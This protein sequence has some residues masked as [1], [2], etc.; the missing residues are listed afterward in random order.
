MIGS[1]ELG[2]DQKSPENLAPWR[3]SINRKCR[4][5]VL[6]GIGVRRNRVA[7]SMAGQST[8]TFGVFQGRSVAESLDRDRCGVL[9]RI[10]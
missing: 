2:R 6:R 4:D 7:W 8:H 10:Q 3:K 5:G 9:P 1:G